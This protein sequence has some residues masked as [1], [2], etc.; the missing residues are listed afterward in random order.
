MWVW[1]GGCVCVCV[2]VHVCVHVYVVVYVYVSLRVLFHVCYD[3][4]RLRTFIS[5]SFPTY[6]KVLIIILVLFLILRHFFSSF[7]WIFLFLGSTII[8]FLL[9]I[10][11]GE[12]FEGISFLLNNSDVSTWLSFI[13]F[14][15]F[16]YCGAN[17]G[18]ALT[19]QVCYYVIIYYCFLNNFFPY[20][21]LLIYGCF[22]LFICYSNFCDVLYPLYHI[23]KYQAL[24]ITSLILPHLLIL[25]FQLCYF[26]L[27]LLLTVL[28][29]LLEKL[30]P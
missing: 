18:A 2:C 24:L 12:F 11:S 6:T 7:S 9:A 23:F 5:I 29:I 21:F 8:S 19:H 15:S 27:D 1:V 20:N 3:K 28:Q 16:G 25:F 26:S 30:L 4:D 22:L 13:A 14:C 17:F 10:F